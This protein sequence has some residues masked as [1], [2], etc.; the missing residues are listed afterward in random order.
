VAAVPPSPTGGLRGAIDLSP[1]VSRQTQQ[2]AQ[3]AQ[4]RQEPAAG[5]PAPT[6]SGLVV[7]VGDA[8]FPQLI[9]L[10]STV[11]VVVAL[12]ASWS[13]PSQEL[14]V[15]LRRVV[16]AAAGRL[17]LAIVDADASPQVAAAF[18]AQSIPTV[19]AVIAGQPVPLFAGVLPAEQMAPLFEQVLELAQQNGVTGTVPGAEVDPDAPQ[20]EPEP[21]PLPPLHQEAYAAI[22]Q[23]DYAEAARLFRTAIA[24]DPRDVAAGAALAQVELLDRLRTVPDDARAAAAA[25][26]KDVPAALAVAD[27]DVSGGHVEDAFDRLLDAFSTASGDDRTLIRTRLLDYFAL[28][29]ADDPRVGAARRRLAMLLY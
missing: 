9:E 22:E 7:E 29:G 23:Q 26:P 15:A 24:Q 17:L 13:T 6:A 14:V 25:A 11:P 27:L 8:E 4:A 28:T 18:Q 2:A 5:G 12:V 1:L 10:S 20:P 3:A 19:V 21:E 16:E